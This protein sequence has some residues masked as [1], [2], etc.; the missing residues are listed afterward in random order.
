METDIWV[1]ADWVLD[2]NDPQTEPQL[3]GKLT[4]SVI[5]NKE[6]FSFSYSDEWLNSSYALQIDPELKLFGGRQY[7][8]DNN[9]FRT[10]LDSCPDRWG[11]LLMKRREAVIARQEQRKPSQLMEIDYLLGVH[12]QHRMGGLRFKRNQDGSFLDDN[13]KL[14]APPLSSLR[15]LEYA[16]SQIEGDY[17][18]DDPDYLKWLFMLISPGSSLG[19]ARPK[20]SVI[21]E[22]KMLWIAKFPSLNDDYDVGGWEYI[23][24]RLAKNAGIEMA[25]CQLMK[26][27]NKHHTFLTQ[28]FDRHKNKRL[29]FSS[30]MTQLGYYDGDYE[31][32]YLELAEFLTNQG[33]ASKQDLE[34]LW[35]R[36]IFNIAVSNTDD[37]LRNH[38]FILA[39]NGWRL[40]PA[41]DINP[42]T[43]AHGLH[44]NI[45]EMDNSLDFDL[46]LEVIDYFRLNSQEARDIIDQVSQSVKNWRTEA[47]SIGLSRMEQDLMAD[48]FQY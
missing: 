1:Y 3:I 30:A 36:I 31:A 13:D 32:S 23:T 34:Q 42:V 24:Y 47:K 27:K 37:H 20:A 6:L 22:N 10:F 46:A 18:A 5:R 26:F 45:N 12:D 19:G 4:A 40:S 7:S 44:L 39:E 9:N 29:H 15:E 48:A 8:N 14:A 21:D 41:F 11:R 16:V 33:A 38:G 25:Q 2:K 35:R 43:P 28:R 17:S